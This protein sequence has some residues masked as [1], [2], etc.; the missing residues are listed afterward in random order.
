MGAKLPNTL[1]DVDFYEIGSP[2]TFAYYYN[3]ERGAFYGLDNNLKRF[4]P[5][6]FFLRLRPEVPEVPGL[7][8][9]GQDVFTD[10]FGPS[11]VS[12][13]LCAGKV[14][15]VKNP[16]SLVKYNGNECRHGH[17]NATIN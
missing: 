13:M 1:D 14:L 3:S 6:T 5:K 17:D 11:M 9:T 2:L 16:A 10:G 4:E 12:G 8:L 7:Y 15:G